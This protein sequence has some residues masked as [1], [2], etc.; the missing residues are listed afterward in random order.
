MWNLR[1]SQRRCWRLESSGM[2]RYV[3]G[4][5]VPHISAFIL[6]FKQ[7]TKPDDE[8]TTVLSEVR[9]YMPNDRASHPRILQSSVRLES[10]SIRH[11]S[12]CQY[13]KY[14]IPITIQETFVPMHSKFVCVCRNTL[15][16]VIIPTFQT[17]FWLKKSVVGGNKHI[18]AL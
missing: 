13:V 3:V 18:Y 7:S 17:L 9:N 16:L 10:P 8:G 1:F 4:L 14:H 2:W 6:R 15:S 12:F 5:V 11:F